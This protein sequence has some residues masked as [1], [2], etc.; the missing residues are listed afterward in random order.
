MMSLWVSEYS[1]VIGVH[2]FITKIKPHAQPQASARKREEQEATSE[3][4][5]ETP[6][7]SFKLRSLIVL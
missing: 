3:I 6:F 5:V 7:H 1:R 2:G 4:P